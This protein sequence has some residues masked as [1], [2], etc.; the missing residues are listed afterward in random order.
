M[1]PAPPLQGAGRRARSNRYV[2]PVVLP[3][4]ILIAGPTASGKS[5]LALALAERLGGIVIN[6]DSMQVYRELAILTA[7]PSAAELARA[8]HVLYGHVPAAEAYSVGRWLADMAP[9]LAAAKASGL[10]P[11]V[12]GGTG[13]YFEA[14]LS[15]LSPVPPI[16]LAIRAHWRAEA[17]RLGPGKLHAELGSRDPAMAARLR[18]GD[19]QRV[20]RA[21]EVLAAT[22]RSLA[23]WQT[24]TGASLLSAE[25]T[26]RLALTLPRDEL[27]AR[28][29]TRFDLM[30]ALGAV[31]EVA[32]LMALG[33][34]VSQPAM[35]ATGAREIM[36]HLRGELELAAAIDA[37]K[38]A[39]RQY[40]KRQM[41]WIRGR[42]A[43]WAPVSASDVEG[44]VAEMLTQWN[45]RLVGATGGRP[46][47]P[48]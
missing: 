30:L 25:D 19:R 47:S 24:R 35:R 39:T 16:P 14:L 37:A 8:P 41:T 29:N 6:A 46:I 43:D 20:T 26:V 23:D 4:A 28:C 45:G 13:L 27:H 17:E 12:T 31:A 2:A 21:L 36:G 3:H 32:A 34:P 10:V 48:S 22:G 1:R 44:V 7:R 18:P 9:A 40:A 15:G 38:A 42:M 33:L 5:A 11:I